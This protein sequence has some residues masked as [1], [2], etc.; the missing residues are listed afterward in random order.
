MIA[1][2]MLTLNVFH[3]GIYLRGEDHTSATSS[4]GTVQE[5]RPKTTPN[6]EKAV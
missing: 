6:L 1:L 3:P 4:E 2:A 5:D